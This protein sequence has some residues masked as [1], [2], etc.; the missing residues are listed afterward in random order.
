MI[1]LINMGKYN[2]REHN[3]MKIF[4]LKP[5]QHRRTSLIV[6]GFILL[7]LIS[8]M[9]FSSLFR[10]YS[11]LDLMCLPV[12]NHQNGVFGIVCVHK[13][14]DNDARAI[15]RD[16]QCGRGRTEDKG[17]RQRRI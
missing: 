9:W 15:R 12:L 5:K 7:V 17:C 10:V 14:A 13:A 16:S 3:T 6:G 11:E 8:V 4:D 2:T 1:F